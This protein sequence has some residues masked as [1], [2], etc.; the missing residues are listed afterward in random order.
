MK[1]YLDSEQ[2]DRLLELGFPGPTSISYLSDVIK[3]DGETPFAEYNYSIGELLSFFPH[4]ISNENGRFMLDVFPA[5]ARWHIVYF[6]RNKENE[7]YRWG[8]EKELID[9]MFRA[10]VQLKNEKVI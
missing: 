3:L 4:I 7:L 9:L 5:I 8:G 2:T 10:L 1:Q 6:D